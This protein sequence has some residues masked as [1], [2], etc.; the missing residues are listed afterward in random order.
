MEQLHKNKTGVSLLP[1][2]FVETLDEMLTF[3]LLEMLKR[4]YTVKCCRNCGKYFIQTDKR[5]R[6]YCSRKDENGR[7]CQQK[8][9]KYAYSK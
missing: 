2:Y 1:H 5:K 9:S 8:G 6:F 3:E 4:G 7:T